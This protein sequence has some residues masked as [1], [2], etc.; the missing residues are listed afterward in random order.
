MWGRKVCI[1]TRYRWD[2]WPR[3][4]QYLPGG[5]TWVDVSAPFYLSMVVFLFCKKCSFCIFKHWLLAK[6]QKFI[7]LNRWL[8]LESF[9]H[10]IKTSCGAHWDLWWTV[11]AVFL[12]EAPAYETKLI[13]NVSE[14]WNA[15]TSNSTP[16]HVSVVWYLIKHV[17]NFASIY[18]MNRCINVV[19]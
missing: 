11:V 17:G 8:W 6:V 18:L 1:V 12:A 10:H 4:W 5:S 7:I 13:L 16:L 2:D 14:V 19:D 15:W 9:S 3:D